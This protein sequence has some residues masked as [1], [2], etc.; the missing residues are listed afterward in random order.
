MQHDGCDSV[1]CSSKQ[2]DSYAH[3]RGVLRA[4][5][6]GLTG[7]AIV[8]GADAND[9][10]V[11]V[12]AA[13]ASER[14]ALEDV[15][16]VF[17]RQTGQTVRLS[18]GSSGNLARQIREGAPYDVFLSADPR[19]VRDLHRDG[20]TRDAGRDF[21]L[22]RLAIVVPNGSPLAADGQL[23]DLGAALDDGRLRRFAIANPEHA[24]YGV[25]A[26]QALTRAGLW[27][28]IRPHLVLGENVGQAAQFALSGSSQGGIVAY[29]LALAPAL[30]AHSSAAPIP[31]EWHEP[32][33]HRA[34]LLPSADAAAQRFY[35]FLVSPAA[36]GVFERHGFTLA[37]ATD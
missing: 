19:Y 2:A 17:V 30:A 21:L 10:R 23:R 3:S 37:G 12:V 14:F 5:L 28:R 31:L 35:E 29:A 20:L 16:E 9:G 26:Q 18:F 11:P 33:R 4:V 7:L 25:A 24:P 1:A 22:G 15:A 34:V 13:A 32:V 27:Q 8:C 36:A 6:A